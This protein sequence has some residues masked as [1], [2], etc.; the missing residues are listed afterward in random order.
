VTSVRTEQASSATPLAR[1]LFLCVPIISAIGPGWVVAA[2]TLQ[3]RRET[4][5][6]GDQATLA[7]LGPPSGDLPLDAHGERT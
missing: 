3:T 4:P 7:R 2:K 1:C 6:C 5:W